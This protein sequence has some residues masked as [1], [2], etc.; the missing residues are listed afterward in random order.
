M[1]GTTF[2]FY[3]ARHFLRNVMFIFL[4]FLGLIVSIDLIELSRELG[5]FNNVS[6]SDIFLIA[7]FRAPSFAG[8]VLPFACLFAAVASLLVLNKKLELVVARASGLS[9]WQFLL[10]LL[11]A[12]ALLGLVAAVF[13]SPLS[14]AGQ[15]FS[16]ATEAEA[17]GRVKGSF[18]NKTANFW[19]RVGSPDGDT[20]IRA[21]LEEQ[22]GRRL[23]AVSI[24]VYD[25]TGG[26]KVR[27]DAKRADFELRSGRR[28][29]YVLTNV[30]ETSVGKKSIK[31]E[32][33]VVPVNI[34]PAQLKANVTRA[35]D[36]PIWNLALAA[37]RAAISGNN[38]LPFQ[39]QFHALLAQPLMFVAMV[40]IAAT[41][42]LTF[43]RFGQSGGRI[44]CGILAG[45]VLYVLTKL[46]ITFGSNGLVPPMLAAWTPA[47]VGTLIGVTILLYQEDG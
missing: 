34:T 26:F 5:K 39:T 36:V 27:Y 47:F 32:R 4:L 10:P 28:N 12:A 23:T 29:Q 3:L 16:R 38:P 11:V 6:F 41:I 13:Y 15:Q 40:L 9:V 37:Q 2:S 17:F 46:V 8:E 20:I 19:L 31:R 1:I 30:S 35:Q 43:A 18:S 44:L 45:F 25:S 22:N 7:A 24:Y 42:S 33:V 21:K 14:V